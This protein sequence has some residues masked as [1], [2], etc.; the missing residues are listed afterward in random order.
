MS[1]RVAAA[2]VCVVTLASA[3]TQPTAD[4]TF[5]DTFL[6]L[7][8]HPD[9]SSPR[10]TLHALQDDVRRAYSVLASAYDEHR[11]TPGFIASKDVKK[12]VTTAQLLLRQAMTT[13]DLSQVPAVDRQRIGIETVLLLKEI[14]DR[15]PA[16]PADS[17]PGP[18]DIGGK[19]G[20]PPLQVWSLPYAEIQIVRIA[21]GQEAGRYLFS[22]GTVARVPEFYNLMKDFSERPNADPDFFDFYTLTPGHLL[23]PKWYLWIEE[24]PAWTRL[25]L[26]GQAVWQWVGLFLVVAVLAGVYAAVWRL[27]HHRIASAAPVSR[28]AL[29]LLMTILIALATLAAQWVVSYQLNITDWPFIATNAALY[30]IAALAAALAGYFA[31]ACLAELI[32]A[33]P[34][35]NSASADA[36]LLRISARVLG[37]AASVAI[38][39]YG[40]REVGISLYGVLAGLGVGGLALGLAARPTL[41]NLIGGL[42]L[43][44]DRPVH[45]GDFCQFDGAMGTVEEIGLRSTRVRARDRTLITI[46]NAEFSNMQLVNWSRRDQALLNTTLG[47]RY[48]TTPEQM[49][50]VTRR[51]RELLLNHPEADRDKVRVRFHEFGQYALGIEIRAYFNTTDISHFLEVQEELLL[52]IMQI[53]EDCGTEMAFPSTTTYHVMD[54]KAST[55]LRGLARRQKRPEPEREESSEPLPGSTA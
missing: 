30:S 25:P 8:A 47:L 53:V 26:A 9:L 31:F 13:L 2:L 36:S 20:K 50:E 33:S 22:S 1:S 32:V 27:P 45:V 28:A 39:L 38:I 19:D 4:Q 17:I 43:Y 10:S 5:D 48:E 6:S 37:I 49:R 3:Q 29:R 52:E 40:A 41:E 23:P 11:H 15:L 51:V 44:A 7:L 55:L 12:K 24:L 14:L 18:D 54:G 16:M 42:T 46:P 21:D 35:I 34:R